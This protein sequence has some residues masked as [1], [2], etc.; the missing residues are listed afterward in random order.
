M[1]RAWLT[2][3]LFALALAVQVI[4]PMAGSLAA[5]RESEADGSI[6]VCLK[7]AGAGQ[8]ERQLPG[9]TRNGRDCPICQIFCDGV[10]PV[11]ARPP[12]PGMA[13]VQW[14]EFCWTAA[15]RVLP[16]LSHG[17]ANRARAPPSFS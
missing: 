9:H 15:D 13:P 4:A 12:T 14:F 17:G 16:I 6:G 2:R 5:A 1:P 10:A 3:V 8:A 11:A 7:G